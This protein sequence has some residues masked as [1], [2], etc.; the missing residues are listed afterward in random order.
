MYNNPDGKDGR[1][2]CSCLRN[3]LICASLI[4]S[5][6]NFPF[7]AKFIMVSLKLL[8]ASLFSLYSSAQLAVSIKIHRTGQCPPLP[9]EVKNL[10][11]RKCPV[12]YLLFDCKDSYN[13]AIGSINHLIFTFVDGPNSNE[14][15]MTDIWIA[16]SMKFLFTG[17]YNNAV[18]S[19][20][21]AYINEVYRH[22]EKWV[23]PTV[24]L[25]QEMFYRKY[26]HTELITRLAMYVIANCTMIGSPSHE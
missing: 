14:K 11:A 7:I 26:A 6:I 24:V 25:N 10:S 20:T 12:V 4:Y 23:Y 19:E 13:A 15:F 1:C 22:I 17:D 16:A 18:E 5:Q 8:T 21:K 9:T 3:S 2:S